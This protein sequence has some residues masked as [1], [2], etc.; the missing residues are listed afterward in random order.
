M[1]K[2]YIQN[3]GMI[4]TNNCPLNCRHCLRGYSFDKNMSKKIIEATLNQTIAIGNL[5]ICGGE[6]TSA[7]DTIETIFNYIVDHKI[8]VSQ[9]SITINGTNYDASFIK[10]LDYINNY[11]PNNNIILTIS[12]DKYHMQELERLNMKKAYFENIRRYSETRYFYGLRQLNKNLKLFREGNAETLDRT[13]TIDLKPIDIIVTYIGKSQKFDRNGLCNI[14]PLMAVNPEGII[15]EEN[16]SIEHQQTLYN[17][18]NVLTDTFEEVAL[19]R[20]KIVKPKKWEKET[21]KIIKKY[22]TYNR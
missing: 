18:G 16:A 22:I 10:L 9:I 4:V 13:L 1:N 12:Y 7:I 20:G 6:P 2:V 11:I 15:T 17:Y 14:G 3:L 19:K 5:C 21:S 8:I